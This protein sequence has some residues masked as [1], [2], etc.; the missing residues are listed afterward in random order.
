MKNIQ[1]LGPYVEV[2]EARSPENP[3][4]II[5]LGVG[6]N[7]FQQLL[8]HK[9]LTPVAQYYGIIQPGLLPAIHCFRGLQRPMM[10]GDDMEADQHVLVY[11]WRPEMDYIWTGSSFNGKPTPKPTPL[12]IV[13]AVLVHEDS[14]NEHGVEGSVERWNWLKEDP[15]LRQA[16]IDWQERYRTKLWSRDI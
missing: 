12:G 16:P 6:Q 7:S 10:L 2:I 8:H 14:N 11:S 13:L 3:L 9:L 15:A 1:R 4:S 5:K